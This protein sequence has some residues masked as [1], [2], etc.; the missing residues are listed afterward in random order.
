MSA[1]SVAIGEGD[2]PFYNS[3]D[4]APLHLLRTRRTTR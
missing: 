2:V 3:T 4:D 1:A